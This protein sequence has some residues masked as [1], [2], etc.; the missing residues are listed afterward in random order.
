VRGQVISQATYW[1]GAYRPNPPPAT[2]T[3]NVLRIRGGD[4]NGA[5]PLVAE[6][7]TDEYGFDVAL[8]KGV[9]CLKAG[10]HDDWFKTWASA[11]A[12]DYDRACLRRNYEACDFVARLDEKGIDGIL[13]HTVQW[14]P[15]SYP[16]RTRPY[17]G[18]SPP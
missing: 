3:G 5:Q 4:R 12:E 11:G 14:N 8:P 16:C 17:R 9:W 7:T 1:G 10:Y 13:I 6:V 2:V 18:S 15:P